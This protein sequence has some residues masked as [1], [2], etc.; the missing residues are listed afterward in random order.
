MSNPGDIRLDALHLRLLKGHPMDSRTST[1]PLRVH[2]LT[3]LPTLVAVVACCA[4]LLHHTAAHAQ[5]PQRG[6]KWQLAQTDGAARVESHRRRPELTPTG[7]PA[8]VLRLRAY[9]ASFVHVAYPIRP[10]YA[11]DEVRL[12]ASV[13]SDQ[14]GL[15]LLARVVFPRSLHPLTGRP[16][17]TLIPG[18][19][20]D[21]PGEWQTLVV[22]ETR[23]AVDAAGQVLS[24]RFSVPVDTTEA[25]IDTLV[26]NV[27]TGPGVC[28]TWIDEPE[29]SGLA[30]VSDERAR[31]LAELTAET[32]ESSMSAGEPKA[33]LSQDGLLLVR[34]RP[35]FARALTYRGESPQQIAAAGFNVVVFSSPPDTELLAAT[36]SAGLWWAASFDRSQ[37]GDQT[38]PLFESR[39][40]AWL[41]PNPTDRARLRTSRP[42]DWAHPAETETYFGIVPLHPASLVRQQALLL[43]DGDVAP[44]THELT[45]LR[46][47]VRNQ[48]SVGCR[49]IWFQS[50]YG[51]HEL[52]HV[53]NIT[54]MNAELELIA[55]WLAGGE[56]IERPTEA[57]PY[58]VYRLPQS[59]L[60]VPRLI[61]GL[62]ASGPREW[63]GT[64]AGTSDSLAAYRLAL[65]GLDVIATERV[66][67]G[68]R[69][70][71]IECT[72]DS[73]FVITDDSLIIQQLASQP[74]RLMK[75][76]LPA[77]WQRINRRI[78]TIR[79]LP[80]EFH[81][82][83]QANQ[84]EA[85]LARSQRLEQSG[86]VG[87]AFACLQNSDRL[88]QRWEQQVYRRTVM[89]YPVAMAS[90]CGGYLATLPAAIQLN[91][92]IRRRTPSLN[93]LSAG[94][95]ENP[96]QMTRDGW[97]LVSHNDNS[98]QSTPTPFSLT[99][100][101]R[102]DGLRSLLLDAPASRGTQSGQATVRQVS[103]KGA[104][105]SADNR[106]SFDLSSPSITS[107]R[108]DIV[109]LS[110]SIFSADG[111]ATAPARRRSITA[112]LYVSWYPNR[113]VATF[114]RRDGWQSF[115]IY[116][117]VPNDE[118][119]RLELR[120]VE[121]GSCVDQVELFRYSAA[122]QIPAPEVPSVD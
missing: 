108:G 68:L 7:G 22:T 36:A 120:D 31:E 73:C 111:T 46:A 47:L 6:L 8:E 121:A 34:D 17:T 56:L 116:L 94:N 33:G 86:D 42:A 90:P 112:Q 115:D 19:R 67:G 88:T 35:L 27:Y 32:S 49:G 29:L 64:V 76:V 85:I 78:Q 1:P 52:S 57:K 37:L 71:A 74:V 51:L 14:P 40:I 20:Y 113:P 48:L 58:Y 30:P 5:P 25:V 50:E 104:Q 100:L 77:E 61:D 96:P 18:T 55:P 11:I 45:T 91:E 9:N 53:A 75:S 89:Q 82:P 87:L 38:D 122:T 99:Q 102:R 70:M 92:Q 2:R 65:D 93:L 23:S 60:I 3:P 117:A 66:A 15:Q 62:S 41:D 105:T 59:L 114:G 44:F 97:T 4:G 98:P 24:A 95:F 103:Y 16:L 54:R 26:L 83:A 101:Q 110:G 84:I 81:D 21:H 63:S 119:L 107:Q 13:R 69:L 39:F 79:Q 106:S 12:Q 80:R 10:T 118:P 109:R 28:E 72:V 43:S